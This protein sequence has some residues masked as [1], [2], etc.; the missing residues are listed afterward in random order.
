VRFAFEKPKEYKKTSPFGTYPEMQFVENEKINN[1][2][3]LKL[4]QPVR[5][6]VEG[7]V[8]LKAVCRLNYDYTMEGKQSF[9]VTATVQ[10]KKWQEKEF[11]V[12]K[13]ETGMYKNIPELIPSTP[14]NFYLSVPPGTFT[15]DFNLKGTLAKTAGISFYTKPLDAY[16]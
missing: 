5:V 12:I 16:E 7:P 10:G 1:F 8:N 4:D 13:S 2:S 6:K 11:T 14:R 3:Q 15:I 9:T